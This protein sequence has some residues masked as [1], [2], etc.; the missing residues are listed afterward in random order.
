MIKVIIFD[1]WST[2]QY[3]RYTKG[4]IL[5]FWKT[6]GRKHPYRKVL[7]AFEKLFQLDG[8]DDLRKKYS[9][10]FDELNIPKTDIVIR[11]SAAYRKRI[12]TNG[13]L[14]KYVVPLMKKLKKK[15]YKIAVLSNITHLSA[16]KAKKSVLKDYVNKFFFSYQIGSIKP[17]TK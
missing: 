7:K 10:L 16:V 3:K 14:Y 13:R 4:N 6:F 11:K 12:D 2:L 15:G 5:W 8:S 17:N 1:L 9:L